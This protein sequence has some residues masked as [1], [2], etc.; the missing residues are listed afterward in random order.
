M[1]KETNHSILIEIQE[2]RIEQ[3][4]KEYQERLERLKAESTAD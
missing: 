4:R 3:K 2:R 1:S